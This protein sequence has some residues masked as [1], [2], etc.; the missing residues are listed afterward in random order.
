MLLFSSDDGIPDG[1]NYHEHGCIRLD[2]ENAT[3]NDLAI[4]EVIARRGEGFNG[5]DGWKKDNLKGYECKVR[6][7]RRK[8]RITMETENCGIH[9]KSTTTIPQ[10]YD[11]VYLALTGD[12]CALTDI[13]VS[14]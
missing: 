4:N 8:N 6:L 11:S 3:N 13:R 10:G 2:G 5:W 12:Q 14:Y 7:G 1:K 9:V